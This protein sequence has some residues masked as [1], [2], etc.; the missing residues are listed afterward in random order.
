LATG[1]VGP[2]PIFISTP[3][4]LSDVHM[5]PQVDGSLPTC[6]RQVVPPSDGIPSAG[7]TYS[8]PA[9]PWSDLDC[10]FCHFWS[11]SPNPSHH[12]RSESFGWWPGTV[13]GDLRTFSQVTASMGDG[14]GHGGFSSARGRGYNNNRGGYNSG[15]GKMV[16][17]REDAP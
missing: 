8:A 11:S 9:A 6:H 13:A 15:R 7:D 14:G 17:H 2:R 4:S 16:W 5:C 3:S 10:I 12:S 1:V